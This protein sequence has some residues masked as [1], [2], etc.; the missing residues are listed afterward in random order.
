MYKVENQKFYHIQRGAVPEGGHKWKLGKREYWGKE[1][2]FVID[3]AFRAS[4]EFFLPIPGR[5][6]QAERFDSVTWFFEEMI[7]FFETGQK[8]PRFAPYF[9]Y[10]PVM[11]FKMCFQTL[12]NHRYIL[13]EMVFEEVRKELN[14]ELPSRHTGLWVIKDDPE[15]LQYWFETLAVDDKSTIITFE[16]TGKIHQ[17]NIEYIPEAIYSVDELRAKALKYW[18]SFPSTMG[19][20]DEYLFEGYATVTDISSPEKFGLKAGQFNTLNI[21][22]AACVNNYKEANSNEILG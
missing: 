2:S 16:L 1:R 18:N 7:R 10:N 20:R 21:F 15:E 17:G 13:R 8:T 9:D 4:Y 14:K 3:S 12:H 22:Q 6:Q 19:K 11:A 5:E